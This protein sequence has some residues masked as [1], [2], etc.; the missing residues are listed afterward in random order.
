MRSS[1]TFHLDAALM[2]STLFH[3]LQKAVY[4]VATILRSRAWESHK[5]TFQETLDHLRFTICRRIILAE[6]SLGNAVRYPL[7]LILRELKYMSLRDFADLVE[8]IALTI[9]ST[10]FALDLLLE[11]IELEVDGILVGSPSSVR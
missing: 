5:T 1:S 3:L 4:L 7:V 8:L 11:V 9:G 6:K 2:I 10:E